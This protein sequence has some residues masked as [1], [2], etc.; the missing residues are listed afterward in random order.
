MAKPSKKT[1]TLIFVE[2]L[3]NEMLTKVN[4]HNVTLNNI[5]WI[6]VNWG[7]HKSSFT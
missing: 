2:F 4:L 5:C 7:V 6:L 3:L 1:I